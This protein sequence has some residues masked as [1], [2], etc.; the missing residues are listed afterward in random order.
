MADIID[1]A[2][3]M[4]GR[5]LAGSPRTH[6]RHA[7]DPVWWRGRRRAGRVTI[8]VQELLLALTVGLM[9][10]LAWPHWDPTELPGQAVPSE[11]R[12]TPWKGA[13]RVVDGDTFWAGADKIRIADID[14]PELKAR[15]D[16]EAVLARRAT[17]RLD[18]LL[19]AG[20]FLMERV[21]DRDEDRYG[22]KLR[23]V[24]RDG[25]SLGDQLVSEGLARTWI[26][27]REP[28]C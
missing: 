10:G 27:R 18:E 22:R 4:R 19:T 1:L 11:E 7:S 8:S 3:R 14:T 12:D 13:V 6:W 5:P 9:L 26:G 2:K 20:P 15:C 17:S 23:I 25:R 28:W 16:R 21:G 24:T